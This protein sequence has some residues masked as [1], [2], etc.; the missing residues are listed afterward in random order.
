MI[1]KLE[2]LPKDEEKL[3][4][5]FAN[6]VYNIEPLTRFHPL[7]FEIIETIRGRE[8]DRFLFGSAPTERLS[9]ITPNPHSLKSIELL[10]SPIAKLK[11]PTVYE[12]L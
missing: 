4:G 10:G 5:I 6:Y 3:L 7:G 11:I 8:F 1:Q 12:G 9:N 2:D